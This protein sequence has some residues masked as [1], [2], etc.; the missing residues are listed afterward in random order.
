MCQSAGIRALV[1]SIWHGG[2]EQGL[3]AREHETLLSEARVVKRCMTE[4]CGLTKRFLRF[5]TAHIVL[6]KLISSI[7]VLHIYHWWG[8]ASPVPPFDASENNAQHSLTS[9]ETKIALFLVRAVIVT[10]FLS[11]IVMWSHSHAMWAESWTKTEFRPKR[12][13]LITLAI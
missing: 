9:I 4:A 5:C 2:V 6:M 12:I 3:C 10:F 11:K 8:L 1:E 13:F 7:N